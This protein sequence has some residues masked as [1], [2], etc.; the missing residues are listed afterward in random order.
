VISEA[1][2][3]LKNDCLAYH[4]PL[5]GVQQDKCLTCHQLKNR[6]LSSV[7]G[8]KIFNRRSNLI[9]SLVVNAGC[10][11][12]HQEHKGTPF[13]TAKT[14]FTHSSLPLDIKSECGLCHSDQKPNDAIHSYQNITCGICHVVASWKPA[15]FADH[16]KYFTL[17]G[18]HPANCVSCHPSKIS[19]KEYTCY[20]C[21]EH[22]QSKI[23]AEHREE[24]IVDITN[25]V[26][27]HR[28]ANKDEAKK[29]RKVG[30]TQNDGDHSEEDD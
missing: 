12:C 30:E 11:T 20:S 27:C 18:N 29:E 14:I 1:H 19:F 8:A 23:L 10:G 5:K 16:Q 13:E 21:H 2:K 17:D 24:G 25:C 28:S 26:K 9:H 22:S 3:K 4:T 7:S 6:R 15:T